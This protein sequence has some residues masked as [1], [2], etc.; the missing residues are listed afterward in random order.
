VAPT[1]VIDA[2]ALVAAVL[3]ASS[4][5]EWAWDQ[6]RTGTLVA[7]ELVSLEVANVMRKAVLRGHVDHA[8]GWEALTLAVN[9]V[10]DFYPHRGFLQ[11]VWETRNHM[12]S[13][14][15]SYVHLARVLEVPLVTL[16]TG[17]A[18]AAEKWCQVLHPK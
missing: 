11:G 1:I 12:S 15:A 3:P 8:T 9:C 13:Y 7:P 5:S 14:D 2:S 18:K 17:L 6:C 16:D 4:H 10:S